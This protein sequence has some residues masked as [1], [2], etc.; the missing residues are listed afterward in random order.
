MTWSAV[1]TVVVPAFG[2]NEEAGVGAVEGRIGV[3]R[4]AVGRRVVFEAPAGDGDGKIFAGE[5]VSADTLSAAHS[6]S[7]IYKVSERQLSGAAGGA[8]FRKYVLYAMEIS[9]F[10]LLPLR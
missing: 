6:V 2:L 9:P 1:S 3:G 8:R 5:A 7:G 10:V 4:A